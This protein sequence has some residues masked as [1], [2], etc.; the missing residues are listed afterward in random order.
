VDLT[1]YDPLTLDLADERFRVS[2]LPPEERLLISIGAVGLVQPPL[3]VVR[4]GKPV[5][6]SGWKRV[7]ACRRL[8]LRGMKAWLRNEPDDLK[9]FRLA[10]MENLAS[11]ELSLMEKAETVS[12]LMRFG[13][14]RESL[15]EETLPLLG[16]SRR[17]ETLDV[18]LRAAAMDSEVKRAASGELADISVLDAFLRFGPEERKALLPLLRR[19]GR[20]KQREILEDLWAAAR[21]EGLSPLEVLAAGDI[22]EALDAPRRTPGQ[23]VDL[24]RAA[25]KRRRYP[26]ASRR[27]EEFEGLLKR[28]GWPRRAAAEPAPFF[29]DDSLTV[30]FRF[31][32]KRELQAV[33]SEMGRSSDT[34][35]FSA[36]LR[37]GEEE[38]EGDVSA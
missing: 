28:S 29:E 20:N 35:E 36:A 12:R 33:L 27:R 3:F 13:T 15:K 5:L 19:A 7:L 22:R 11:R 23:K 21:R 10:V 26:S 34:K 30:R 38:G 1:S 18:L 16:F 25:L 9:C 32:T 2:F 37:L 24:L 6:L 14:S 17:F 8:G 4:E 31:R